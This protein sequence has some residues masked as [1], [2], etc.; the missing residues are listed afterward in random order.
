MRAGALNGIAATESGWVAVGYADFGSGFQPLAYTSSD[1]TSWSSENVPGAGMLRDVA[2][3]NGMIVAV[4]SGQ[5]LTKRAGDTWR[6]QLVDV[7]IYQVLFG[8][9]FFYAG[10]DTYPG[11]R[12]SSDGINWVDSTFAA[13]TGYLNGQFVQFGQFDGRVASPGFRTSINARGWS[14]TEEPA[15]QYTVMALASV[16]SQIVG[17]AS[18]ACLTAGC[19]SRVQLLGPAGTPLAE[20]DLTPIPDELGFPSIATDGS[21]V[22]VANWRS[23]RATITTTTLPIGSDTWS[24]ANLPSDR[25]VFEVS[26]A[27]GV[28]V[29]VGQLN[30][31]PDEWQPLVLTSTDGGTWVEATLPM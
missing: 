13:W 12:V 17:F 10:A 29:A 23:P 25:N 30:R 24:E 31:F 28:F 14:Q 4:G 21:R 5:I 18:S 11:S 22:V 27:H 1:A 20:L 7:S 26:F 8:N 3:G 16:G 6:S 2:V 19:D 15:V 9:G